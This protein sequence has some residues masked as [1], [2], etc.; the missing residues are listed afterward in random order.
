MSE[1]IFSVD[2]NDQYQ[3]WLQKISKTIEEYRQL[4]DNIL[5]P[6]QNRQSDL[7][8]SVV[9]GADSAVA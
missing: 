4:G 1:K 8:M 6:P 9:L 2:D 5:Q 3:L 7:N